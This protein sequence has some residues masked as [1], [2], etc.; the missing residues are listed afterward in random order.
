MKKSI[1]L[2]M[3]LLMAVSILAAC[4]TPAADSADCKDLPAGQTIKIESAWSRSTMADMGSNMEAGMDMTKNS[5]AYMVIHNCGKEA[6]SLT[7][8]S[9]D[10]S[11][12]TSLMT[13]EI[14]NGTA[15]MYDVSKIELPAG[16]KVELKPGSYHIMLM[17]LTK[18]LMAN[19]PVGLKLTFEKAGE[20]AVIAPAKAP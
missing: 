16:K 9:S 1:A 4:S 8:A 15:S 19:D 3:I 13:T 11:E 5:A 14:K 10:V 7:A 18:G 20:I 17:G 6:D 2:F 12:M